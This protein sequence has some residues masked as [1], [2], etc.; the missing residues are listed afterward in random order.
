MKR[1]CSASRSAGIF[2]RSAPL[3][4]S[5]STS[6]SWG[7]R[8]QRIEHLARR[9]AEHPRRDRGQ[10]DP[11]VL[12]RLLDALDLAGAFLDLGFAVTDEV[13][14][15]ALRARRHEARADQAV[16]DELAAPLGVL[17]VALAAGDMVWPDI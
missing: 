8:D 4:R 6:G 10:L 5:A 3:A 2:L 14:Q 13:A 7:A 16:L 17:D 12:Q 15:F 11:G 9:H 1:P